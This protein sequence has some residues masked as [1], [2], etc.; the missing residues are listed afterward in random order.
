MD[1]YDCGQEV[2]NSPKLAESPSPLDT[3]KRKKL[4]LES[5]LKDVDAAIEALEANPGVCQ[6]LELLAKAR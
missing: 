5:K 6:V 3:L 1:S 4:G 2:A